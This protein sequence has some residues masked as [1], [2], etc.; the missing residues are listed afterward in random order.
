MDAEV[1]TTPEQ[2]LRQNDRT[3]AMLQEL[4]DGLAE[5]TSLLARL[6]A[7]HVELIVVGGLAAVAQGAPITTMDLD[8]VHR[9]T[10]EN[11]ERL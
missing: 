7:S 1:D 6:A 5:L 10:H 4:R 2:R 9:R 11:I 3:L 8:I